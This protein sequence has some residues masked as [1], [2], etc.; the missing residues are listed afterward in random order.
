MYGSIG[1]SEILLY[2]LELRIIQVL[3]YGGGKE[4]E[5]EMYLN[6]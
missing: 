4:L 2:F 1:S 6:Y 3:G 5:M